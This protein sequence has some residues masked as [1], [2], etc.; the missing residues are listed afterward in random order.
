MR[1][2]LQEAKMPAERFDFNNAEGLQLAALSTALPRRRARSRC[3]RTASP[4][5]STTGPHG[6]SPTV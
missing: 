6:A 5:A 4:V 1:N 3:L 2:P